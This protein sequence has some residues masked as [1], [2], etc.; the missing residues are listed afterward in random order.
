MARSWIVVGDRT[1]GGGVVTT[2]SSTFTVDGHK[3]AC[4][5][6]KATCELHGGEQTITT[7]DP[8]EIIDGKPVARDG[9]SLGCGCKLISGKQVAT[10]N[11]A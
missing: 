2:G 9:D 5:G 3:L 7:G 4:V 6:D 1:T 10:Y 8:S 11:A